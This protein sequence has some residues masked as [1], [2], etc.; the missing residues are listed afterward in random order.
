MI[1]TS[2]IFLV[3][4]LMVK[5]VDPFYRIIIFIFESYATTCTKPAALI[6]GA[7]IYVGRPF[8]LFCCLESFRTCSYIIFAIGNLW[9]TLLAML[10][11]MSTRNLKY[12]ASR[13][14]FYSQLALA[15]K[16]LEAGL[17]DLLSYGLAA[18]FWGK[19]LLLWF[20]ITQYKLIE[21]I[22]Y[23]WLV[24]FTCS[25]I[26][27]ILMGVFMIAKINDLSNTFVNHLKHTTKF[28]YVRCANG[29]YKHFYR[30]NWKE[31]TAIRSIQINLKQLGPINSQFCLDYIK[32]VSDRTIDAI[33]IF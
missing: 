25:S 9:Y 14:K 32:T 8:L 33:L 24:V 12:I 22:P 23:L 30:I 21:F 18:V 17:L 5:Q 20:I 31:T 11:P 7:L 28:A 16:Q 10:S 4:L 3:I 15:Y 27:S 26:S 6:K 1:V 2:P 13:L 19:V 29:W